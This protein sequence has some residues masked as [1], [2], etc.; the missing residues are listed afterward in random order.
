MRA[1]ASGEAESQRATAREDMRSKSSGQRVPKKITRFQ[2]LIAEQLCPTVG[3]VYMVAMGLAIT[4]TY[5]PEANVWVAES[6]TLPIITE[7]PTLDALAAKLPGIIQD[8]NDDKLIPFDLVAH[9]DPSTQST[10]KRRNPAPR[11]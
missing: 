6:E 5:D 2:Y 4:A 8:L 3:Y 1:T 10:A 11:P 9:V 7:A